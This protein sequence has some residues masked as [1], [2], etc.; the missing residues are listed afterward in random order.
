MFAAYRRRRRGA[1][2]QRESENNILYRENFKSSRST[3]LAALLSF[4]AYVKV[5][6]YKNSLYKIS[7]FRKLNVPSIYY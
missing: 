1:P 7:L 6:I 3:A 2:A 4:L 5:S